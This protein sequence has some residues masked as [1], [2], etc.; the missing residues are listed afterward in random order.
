VL[1][2]YL[3]MILAVVHRSPV[4]G[5]DHDVRHLHLYSKWPQGYALFHTYVVLGQ[6]APSTLVALPWFIW[7]A[8]RFRTARP[9][10]MLG[11]ALI[12]L[13]VSVGVVKM[14]TGRLGPLDTFKVDA[15]FRGG[16]IFPSGHTANTVVL[17]GVIAMLVVEYGLRFRRTVVAA[18]V[19][20]SATVGLSTVWLVT[21]WISDVVAG[22]FAGV[23]VL[24]ALPT[25]MPYSE[26]LYAAAVSRLRWRR[27]ERRLPRTGEDAERG[28]EPRIPANV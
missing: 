5:W 28:R 3:L 27:L 22:W 17:Y 26:R 11:T 18:A 19:F 14:L 4:L 21:H 1:A 6:R 25:I 24:L 7:L 20:L 8:W 10:L 9:L 15:V 13:N 23:L 2:L 12:V 16:N